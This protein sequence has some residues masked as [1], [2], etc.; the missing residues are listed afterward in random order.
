V[1]EKLSLKEPGKAN[2][3]T[4]VQITL[5][6]IG[7]LGENLFWKIKNEKNYS[8]FFANCFNWLNFLLDNLWFLIIDE[9]Y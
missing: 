7:L 9:I 6:V 5:N 8:S 2:N 1:G 3:F 4:A